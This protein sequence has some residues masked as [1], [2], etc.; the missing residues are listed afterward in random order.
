MTPE[1]TDK[2]TKRIKKRTGLY[3]MLFIV[4][5]ALWII[6]T[7][8][9]MFIGGFHIIPID[10]VEIICNGV[11]KGVLSI[12]VIIMILAFDDVITILTSDV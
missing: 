11:I 1:E 9:F 3:R 8:L 5:I 2:I 12:G 4:T 7:L 10:A 6:K